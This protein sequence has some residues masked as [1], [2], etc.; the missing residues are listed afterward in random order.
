ML[1][2]RLTT[3]RLVLRQL[4]A[5]DFDAF[6]EQF[7][8]ADAMAPLKPLADRRTAWQKLASLNG[9]WTLSGAGWW[10]VELRETTELAGTVGAFFRESGDDLEIGWTI[11]PRFRRKGI[12]V[13]SARLA[14]ADGFARH[15]V[16][17]AIAH[18][19]PPNIAS[20]RVCETLGMSLEGEV[21]FNGTRLS[22]YVIARPP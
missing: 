11:F 21:D 16:K 14:L 9:M 1:V 7:M 22:R 20:I 15:A 4:E 19:D 18:V 12:A 3:A 8:S 6:A 5:R 17:R 10:G 2:P 13:E